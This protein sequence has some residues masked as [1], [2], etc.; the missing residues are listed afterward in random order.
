MAINKN[1]QIAEIKKKAN[2][3]FNAAGVR[4]AA[5]FGSVARGEASDSSDIDILVELPAEETF[6]GL[7]KLK[8]D[9]ELALGTRVDVLTYGSISPLL[10]ERIGKEQIKIYG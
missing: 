3:V 6:L 7:I 9:L 4:Q 8:L 1:F 10:T 5:I 2:P